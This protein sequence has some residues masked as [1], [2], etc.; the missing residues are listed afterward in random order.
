[1]NSLLS[2]DALAATFVRL[3]TAHHYWLGY[4]GGLDSHV[5]L[6]LMQA[7]RKQRTI[8][9]TAVHVNHGLHPDADE[10]QQHCQ[11]VCDDLAVELVIQKVDARAPVGHSPEAYARQ[12]RYDALAHLMQANDM[13]LTAHHCDDQAETLILQLLRGAGPAGLASMPGCKEFADGWHARPLLNVTR[14][15]L[16]EFATRHNLDWIEDSSN[17]DTDL[18]RNFVRHRVMPLLRERWPSVS[19]TLGRA[20]DLQASAAGL[21]RDFAEQDFSHVAGDNE[22]TIRIDPLLELGRDRVMNCLRYWLLRNHAPAAGRVH[23]EAVLDE[24]IASREDSEACVRW[25]DVEIRKYRGQLYLLEQQDDAQ[26]LLCL[27]WHPGES[28][29][30]PAGM[31]TS[32]P[33]TGSGIR[34]DKRENDHYQI[35][36]RQGGE[37]IRPAGKRDTRELKKLLQESGVA[38]W[39]RNRLPLIF[40]NDQLVAVPGVCVA[41]EFAA[42]GNEPG[43]EL[44]LQPDGSSN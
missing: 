8:H 13:L 36:Y 12:C 34:V 18:D 14:S 9:F 28:F 11:R 32:V 16:R 3:P 33:V 10:W 27:E 39:Q 17:E 5:L 31:L 37:K 26:D 30:T 4:S 20:A 22:K 2:I 15:M 23:L 41:D 1:M 21:L 38:P 29:H 42:T 6:V 25:A 35:R 24:V 7:L 40:H 19:V 44:V 43:W